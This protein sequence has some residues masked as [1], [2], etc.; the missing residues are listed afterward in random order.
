MDYNS[1][2]VRWTRKASVSL[3]LVWLYVF[4]N[5]WVPESKI[6]LYVMWGV[7]SGMEVM[8]RG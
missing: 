4:N 5:G 3:P 7:Y 8:V 1:R 2:G 6:E